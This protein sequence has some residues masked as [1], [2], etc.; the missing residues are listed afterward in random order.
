MLF[1][2]LFCILRCLCACAHACPVTWGAPVGRSLLFSLPLHELVGPWLHSDQHRFGPWRWVQNEKRRRQAEAA[3]K[4]RQ[5]AEE[6][7]KALELWRAAEG[8]NA[9]PEASM[10]PPV[11]KVANHCFAGGTLSVVR[12]VGRVSVPSFSM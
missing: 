6:A 4:A 8:G 7:Q 11:P 5:A 9:G 10:P 2:R 12:Q 1:F 3:E